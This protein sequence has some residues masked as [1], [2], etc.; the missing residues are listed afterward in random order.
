MSAPKLPVVEAAQTILLGHY[1]VQL[2][3]T[4]HQLRELHF[5][6]SANVLYAGF[7]AAAESAIASIDKRESRE[8]RPCVREHIPCR[9]CGCFLL[10]FCSN[11]QRTGE[12]KRKLGGAEP[13]RILP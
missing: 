10:Q 12:D 7:A 11:A 9:V 13:C 2:P 4:R 6:A 8:E 1:L 3:A 5:A